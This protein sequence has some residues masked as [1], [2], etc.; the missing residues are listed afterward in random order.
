V[1][2]ALAVAGWAAAL[3]ALGVAAGLRACMARRLALVAQAAHE[4]RGPLGAALLGLH[5]VVSDAAGRRRVAAV[6]LELRRAGLALADLD[7]APRGR[8]APDRAEAVDVGA[9]LAEAVDAWRP[10]ACA[11]ATELIVDDR[12]AH[13]LV[14]A[15]RLRLTQAVGNLVLNALEH[16]AGPVRIRVHPAGGRVRIEVRD[17]GP[18]L[19][20]SIAALT[21]DGLHAARRGH[22]LAIAA[23]AVRR[24]GGRLLTAPVSS[25]ACVALELPRANIAGP[26]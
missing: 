5:G 18:G 22:G 24:H 25:G 12:A 26:P 1:T 9:L 11:F 16:G 3:A 4:L 6:E 21:G 15:D 7:A 20:A 8:R 14:R 2:A 23:R 10:L 19:P 13:M 17:H